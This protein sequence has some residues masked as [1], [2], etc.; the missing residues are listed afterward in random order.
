MMKETLISRRRIR[1]YTVC[2]FI[3]PTYAAGVGMYSVICIHYN[4]ISYFVQCK[5]QSN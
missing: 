4:E 5:F 3:L 2:L 1:L